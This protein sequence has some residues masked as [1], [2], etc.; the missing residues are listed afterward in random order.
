MKIIFHFIIFSLLIFSSK[1]YAQEKLLS[2]ANQAIYELNFN[3]A[4]ELIE[5]YKSKEGVTN[6]TKLLE[7]KLLLQKTTSISELENCET[8]L[9]QLAASLRSSPT[10][11]PEKTDLEIGLCIDSISLLLSNTQGR[12]FNDYSK[13]NDLV[14]IESFIKKYPNSKEMEKIILIRDGLI[15]SKIILDPKIESVEL[16]ISKYNN[17]YYKDTANI[18]L[19]DLYFNKALSENKANNFKSFAIRF[20]NSRHRSVILEKWENVEWTSCIQAESRVVYEQFLANFPNTARKHDVEIALKQI[21][22]NDFNKVLLGNSIEDLKQFKLTYPQSSFLPSVE[23][24]IKDLQLL[25]LPFLSADRKYRLY[26]VSSGQFLS[27]KSYESVQYLESGH[28]LLASDSLKGIVDLKGNV[29]IPFEYV[30]IVNTKQNQYSV[31]SK[32]KYGL[33]SLKGE[34]IIAPI[35]DYFY[36]LED[37]NYQVGMGF[38]KK[39]K[40]GVIDNTGKIIIPLLYSSISNFSTASGSYYIAQ[41]IG[42]NQLFNASAQKVGKPYKLMYNLDSTSC[43]VSDGAL[44]GLMSINGNELISAGWEDIQPGKMNEYILTKPNGEIGI[45]NNLKKELFPFQKVKSISHLENHLYLIDLATTYNKNVIMVFSTETSTFISGKDSYRSVWKVRNNYYAAEIGS[46]VSIMNEK[47]GFIKEYSNSISQATIDNYNNQEEEVY[48]GEGEGEYGEDYEA[49]FFYG[50]LS[51]PTEKASRINTSNI[52]SNYINSLFPITIDGK[53]GYV[54]RSFNIIIP[55]KYDTAEEFANGVA[56]VGV[57]LENYSMQKSIVNEKGKILLNGY[58]ISG[59]DKND[60]TYCLVSKNYSDSYSWYNIQKEQINAL[61][62]EISNYKLYSNFSQ[63]SYRDVIVFESQSGERLMDPNISF[64][65]HFANQLRNKGYELKNSKNYSAAVQKFEEAIKFNS[66]DLTSY[67][68]IADCFIEQGDYNK[69][70]EYLNTGLYNSDD[71]YLLRTRINVY[72]KLSQFSNA[73]SDYITLTDLSIR[74]KSEKSEIAS[75]Y[76]NAG[77]FYVKSKE[78]QNG[79]NAINSGMKY[80]LSEAWAYNN[81]GVCY[82]NLGKEDLAIKDY[83]TAV[84]KCNLCGE[85][86]LALYAHN[87]GLLLIRMKRNSEACVYLNKAAKNDS[88]FENDYNRYCH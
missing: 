42:T 11:I 12:I 18:I 81:R 86:S 52:P 74:S 31:F 13:S 21:E 60:P 20:P 69:A 25:V 9:N 7:I 15:F 88:K 28:F 39:C 76:F 73:A 24:K 6:A 56:S 26:D 36:D 64:N 16:F 59:W 55:L 47:W 3:E 82:D 67:G 44:K 17:S 2:K 19:E 45:I 48:E 61:D 66:A 75:N 62:I 85:E 68:A 65:V 38:G 72:E 27:L 33:F 79:I 40:Y 4:S 57:Y 87:T 35:Y 50:C 84:N 34:K 83:I 54:D 41:S 37:G 8:N 29:I 80:S 51:S 1:S 78:Y 14:R 23:A 22:N 70:L 71:F 58:S 77:Y 43:V 46:S 32:G 30:C 10:F 5:K 63:Y 49:E 53:T